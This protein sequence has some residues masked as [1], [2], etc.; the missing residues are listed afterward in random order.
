MKN[1]FLLI[2]LTAIILIIGIGIIIMGEIQINSQKAELALLQQTINKNNNQISELAKSNANENE[3]IK[4]LKEQPTPTPEFVYRTD[5]VI[6]PQPTTS[7]PSQNPTP[8][9][10]QQSEQCA[11]YGEL[12]S[13]SG[14]CRPIP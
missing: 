8:D 2:I 9:L 10:F 11:A 4:T 12:L 13:P 6:A 7:S 5:T 1:K 14:G 3:E